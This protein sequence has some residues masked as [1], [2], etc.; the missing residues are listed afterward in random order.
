M[1]KICL[2]NLRLPLSDYDHAQIRRAP[3][4]REYT[5]YAVTRGL[6]VREPVARNL[7]HH[8]ALE[9]AVELNRILIAHRKMLS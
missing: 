9:A 3:P 8:E 2:D 6:G 1:T 5:V 4:A 7:T